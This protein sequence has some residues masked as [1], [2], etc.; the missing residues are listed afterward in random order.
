MNTQ[1][2]ISGCWFCALKIHDLAKIRQSHKKP[3]T[4]IVS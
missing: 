1:E 3:F 4:L 2:D